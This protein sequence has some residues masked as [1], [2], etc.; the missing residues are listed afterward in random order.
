MSP[1]TL[2]AGEFEAAEAVYAFLRDSGHLDCGAWSQQLGDPLGVVTCAC[3]ATLR[4]FS[5]GPE[6]TCIRG[7]D[8]AAATTSVL[9]CAACSAGRLDR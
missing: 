6:C 7:N 4:P 8:L 9:D 3:G 1:L 5:A 2:P